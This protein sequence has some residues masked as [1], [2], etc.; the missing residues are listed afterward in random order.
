MSRQGIFYR[1]ANRRHGTRLVPNSA[2]TLADGDQVTV[3][4]HL[5]ESHEAAVEVD[6]ATCFWISA[7]RVSCAATC[8]VPARNRRPTHAE[9]GWKT[10]LSGCP[11]YRRRPRLRSRSQLLRRDSEPVRQLSVTAI[12]RRA[13]HVGDGPYTWARIQ[14]AGQPLA[15]KS[16]T[17]AM[18]VPGGKLER[19]ASR[20]ASVSSGPDP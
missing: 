14:A 9:G 7:C 16:L 13:Q 5:V 4:E 17:A 12:Q 19:N 10:R 20:W 8:S 1:S 6:S 2:W 3:S 18:C 11:S 15:I